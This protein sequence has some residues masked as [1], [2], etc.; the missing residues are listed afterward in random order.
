MNSRIYN[1]ITMTSL[2]LVFD[3]KDTEDESLAG[4]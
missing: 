2:H 3:V 4:F 1:L